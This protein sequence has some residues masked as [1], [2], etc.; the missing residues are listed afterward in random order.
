MRNIEIYQKAKSRRTTAQK[1]LR[2]IELAPNSKP[3]R[4]RTI[5]EAIN[6]AQSGQIIVRHYCG[7]T[8][9]VKEVR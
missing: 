9:I 5:K 3:E 4:Y 6:D 2:S 8:T 1:E 7:G